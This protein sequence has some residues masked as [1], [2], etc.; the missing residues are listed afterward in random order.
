M[1]EFISSSEGSFCGTSEKLGRR[2]WPLLSKNCRNISRS[3]FSP[4][5]FICYP[6]ESVRFRI[7]L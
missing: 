7:L 2:R 3:S 1:P 6:S 5:A 4:N